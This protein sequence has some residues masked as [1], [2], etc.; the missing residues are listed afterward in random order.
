MLRSR[1]YLGMFPVAGL[2]I[3]VCLYSVYTY[4]E[5]NDRLDLLQTHHYSAISEIERLQLATSQIERAILLKGD[6]EDELANRAYQ[7]SKNV[8]GSWIEAGGRLGRAENENGLLIRLL[9]NL[10]SLGDAVVERGE[11]VNTEVLRS[12]VE[13]INDAS[14]NA[15]STQNE[16]IKETNELFRRESRVHYYVVVSSIVTSVLL[17]GFVAYRLSRKILRPIDALAEAAKQL[18]GDKWELSDYRP[19]SRDEIGRLE[20]AFV[21]MATRI[22]DYQ[23]MMNNRL[24]RNRRR[25]EECFNNL[26]HPVVFL[27]ANRKIAYANPSGEE[28]LKSVD[29]EDDLLPQLNSRIETVFGTGEEVVEIDFE[30]SVTVSIDAE[31]THFLPIFVRVDSEEVDDIECGLL[32]QDVTRLR[33][34]DELKSDL[35]AT[36]SHEIKTPV[37]SATMA[38]HLLLEKNVGDLT[39]DQEDLL[40]TA[41]SD[42]NRLK[43]LLNHLLEIARLESKATRLHVVLEKPIHVISTVMEAYIASAENKG[44][45]LVSSV[46]EGLSNV[47]IDLKAIEVGLSNYLSN[48]IKYSPAGSRVEFYAETARGRIR[49]G[50]RDEGPGL[51]ES[52]L[53]KVF[54]KFYRSSAHRKMEGIGLGLSI[55][56]DIA[57]AHGGNAG[58]ELRD[59]GGCDFYIEIDAE[60]AEVRQG[61]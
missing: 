29:W 61:S 23:R 25:M 52:D 22:S 37:T 12:L 34:S 24:V 43:R 30:E 57:I 5:L 2:L 6:G 60:A 36:V 49:F 20:E 47:K 51:A 42:L 19:S 59:Q 38:I 41:N 45:E 1:L 35:V 31:V 17:M 39:E 18:G 54:E 58:C 4:S 27:S 33:L 10:Q 15:V 16:L 46:E 7:R 9:R 56:K 11:E 3:L 14:M 48:A 32:L 28:L 50:V 44:I 26:P 13:Q 21:E 40:N 55:V 8:L 53:E